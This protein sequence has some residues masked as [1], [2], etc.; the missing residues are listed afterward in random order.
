MTRKQ[1]RPSPVKRTL[2]TL[3][4]WALNTVDSPCRY[5]KRVLQSAR[6]FVCTELISCLCPALMQQVA[7]DGADARPGRWGSRGARSG[8]A[9][10]RPG[11]CPMARSAPSRQAPCGPGSGRPASARVSRGRCSACLWLDVPHHHGAVLRACAD[12]PQIGTEAGTV[13]QQGSLK[14]NTRHMQNNLCNIT[15]IDHCVDCV[16][17]MLGRTHR[18]P[19]GGL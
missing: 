9:S 6:L 1:Y 8:R 12:L 7:V 2:R 11:G 17:Y 10:R 15:P 5:E 14:R 18:Q 3:P 4:T 13:C 16:L 19:R